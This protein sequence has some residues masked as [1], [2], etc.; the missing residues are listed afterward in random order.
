MPHCWNVKVLL[1]P[2]GAAPNGM[3]KSCFD[4]GFTPFKC[5]FSCQKYTMLIR[6][7]LTF[8]HYE[9][10]IGPKVYFIINLEKM[11]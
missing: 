3:V 2:E 1:I 9:V 6:I 10:R 11:E 7:S 4:I 5:V 8:D